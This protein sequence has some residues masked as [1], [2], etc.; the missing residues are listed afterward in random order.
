MM[1]LRRYTSS[2]ASLWDAF[3]RDSRNGTFLFE[4][5]YMDYHHDRFVDHSLLFYED[6]RLVALLPANE[7]GTALWSHQ[8][9]TYGGLI[10]STKAASAQVTQIFDSLLMYARENGFTEIHYKPV[11]VI[12]HRVPSQE[13][14]YELW[15]HGAVQEVC[16]LS[17]TIDLQEDALQMRPVQ[18]RRLKVNQLRREGYTVD[19]EAPLDEFWPILT[20][21][22]QQKYDARPVH[23]LQEMESLQRAFPDQILCSVVRNAAGV[24]QGGV[25]LFESQQVSHTQYSSASAEGKQNGVLDCLYLSILENYRLQQGIRFFDFG[26][27]NEDAGRVLNERLIWYKESIGGRGVVYSTFRLDVNQ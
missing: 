2:D 19:W 24:A 25:V 9:L 23:T 21:N 20:D 4:R 17:C 22:L 27:S 6:Q 10:L 16:N 12:Y 14:L 18:T 5:A 11:P 26:T 15:R 7:V 13:D 1:N 8:G 3:V